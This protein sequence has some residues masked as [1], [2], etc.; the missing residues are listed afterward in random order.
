MKPGL[1]TA[2]LMGILFITGCKKQPIQPAPAPVPNEE[3]PRIAIKLN[4]DYLPAAKIDSAILLW[5]LNGQAQQDKMEISND[6]LFTETKNLLKGAGQLTVQIFSKVVLRQQNLQWEK[7]TALTLKEKQSVNW[8]APAN[9]DDAG[10]NPRVIMIDQPSK[11]T[12]IIA[13]RPTDPYFLLKNVP[14]GFRIELERHYTRIPGGAEIVAGGTWKCNTVC[15]DARGIIENREFF[16]PLA[17]QIAGREWK[18]VE[19]GVGLFG[20]NNTSGPGFYF[21]HY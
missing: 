4:N 17:T 18:M 11:F 15:T 13:L 21:N 19:T 16:R 10:W 12:A 1:L 8:K 14:A 9:Y 7:R 5:E 2:A 6:T 20:P 3:H